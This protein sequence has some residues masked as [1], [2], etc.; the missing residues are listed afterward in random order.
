MTSPSKIDVS[1]VETS[2]AMSAVH[3][4]WNWGVQLIRRISSLFR[5]VRLQRSRDHV[6]GS[7]NDYRG[8]SSAPQ[9]SSKRKGL[10]IQVRREFSTDTGSTAFTHSPLRV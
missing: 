6:D 1:D 10:S 8:V 4:R 5:T 7:Q 3:F 9:S 2:S